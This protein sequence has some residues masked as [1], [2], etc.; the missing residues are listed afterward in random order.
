MRIE[1]KENKELDEAVNEELKKN[2][3]VVKKKESEE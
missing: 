3:W 1:E 2:E